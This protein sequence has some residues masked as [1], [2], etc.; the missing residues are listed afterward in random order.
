MFSAG[1]FTEHTMYPSLDAQEPTR[2]LI[3]LKREYLAAVGTLFSLLEH[4]LRIFDPDLSELDLHTAERA[5]QVR[6]F[7]KR[8]RNNRLYVAVHRTDFVAYRAP[9]LISLLGTFSAN[10]FIHQTEGE[11]TRVQDCFLLVDG[12]HLVRRPVAQQRRGVIYLNDPMEARGM[13]ERFDQI[14]ESSSLAVSATTTG[15]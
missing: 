13:R 14:W 10:M 15:L 12:S 3:T 8:S 9:R 5:D 11:A 6:Q 4:E 7:L 1:R 2:I